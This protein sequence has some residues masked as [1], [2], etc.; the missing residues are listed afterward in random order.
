MSKRDLMSLSLQD[1]HALIEQASVAALAVRRARLRNGTYGTV[2]RML[3]ELA[4]F[5]AIH[6]ELRA[7]A[8]ASRAA[9]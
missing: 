9:A 7:K 1:V 6:D 4:T 2:E 3:R 5:E 8:K